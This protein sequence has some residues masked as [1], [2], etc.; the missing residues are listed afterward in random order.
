MIN[1]L[2]MTKKQT[3]IMSAAAVAL[4]FA[5]I[6]SMGVLTFSQAS[7]VKPAFG[8][9]PV[10]AQPTAVE[11]PVVE[12]QR[13]ED[14]SETYT[15]GTQTVISKPSP[16]QAAPNTPDAPKPANTKPLQPTPTQ[17]PLGDTVQGVTGAVRDVIYT[18]K[19]VIPG[20]P[21]SYIGTY[22]QCPFYE[23]AGEKG[24]YPPSDIICNANWSV[25]KP[26]G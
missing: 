13:N 7:M 18:T 9:Q 2:E 11:Q 21:L 19:N 1:L 15:G 14:G 16:T 23:N 17:N 20:D 8:S 6:A 4:G 12:V 5:F 3:L 22:G 24:C 25:C 10:S 26:R